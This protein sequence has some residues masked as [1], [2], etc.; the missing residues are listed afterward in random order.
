MSAPSVRSLEALLNEY[1]GNLFEF[2]VSHELSKLINQEQ[3]FLECINPSMRSMLETQQSYIQKNAAFLLTDLPMLAQKTAHEINKKLDLKEVSSIKVLGKIALASH[4]QEYEE[5]DILINDKTQTYPIS[6]K[7]T[8]S[9]SYINTKSAGLKSFIIK[10]FPNIKNS[11]RMQKEFNERV[12]F[13]FDEMMMKMHEY[14]DISYQADLSEWKN[15]E[16]PSLP[17]NLPSELRSLLHAHYH[18]VSA[19]VYD[20]LLELKANS[21]DE[22]TSGLKALMGDSRED[23]IH[24]TCFYHKKE[25]SYEFDQCKIQKPRRLLLENI[26]IF[27]NKQETSSIQIDVDGVSL[28]LRIKPMNTFIQGSFKLN[29]AIKY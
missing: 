18:Q 21:L 7:L 4:D 23:L 10:Y 1:K 14:Y 9:G 15:Q 20:I 2:L 29:C 28:V 3:L 5:A 16:L 13:L 26:K 22:F 25:N 6:L 27:D 19:C 12:K 8:K 24:V 11:E 17:G